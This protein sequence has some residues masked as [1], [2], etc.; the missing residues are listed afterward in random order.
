MITHALARA[1]AVG[2]TALLVGIPATLAWLAARW[3]RRYRTPTVL[4]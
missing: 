3:I 1:I 2:W 4:A